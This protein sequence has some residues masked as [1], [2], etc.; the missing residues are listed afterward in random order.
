[1]RNARAFLEVRKEFGTFNRYIWRFA[2]DT[3]ID[4]KLAAFSEMPVKTALSDVISRD[5]K[6]RGFTFIGSTIMYAHMQATGMV[7]DHLVHCFRYQE[8]KHLLS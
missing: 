6:K 4:N 7:N 1:V 5:L 3:P 8:L 2:N